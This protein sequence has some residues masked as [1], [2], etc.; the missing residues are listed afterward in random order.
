VNWERLHISGM[1]TA[2]SREKNPT[3]KWYL[4]MAFAARG[5][6]LNMQDLMKLF[7]STNWQKMRKQKSDLSKALQE[8]FGLSGD[9]L[10]FDR[11]RKLY[12]PAPTIRQDT[13]TDLEDWLVEIS[14]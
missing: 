4:L 2:T 6:S 5:P 13:N 11:R 9:P 14:R 8:F 3:D 7:R 1:F 10:P 12:N